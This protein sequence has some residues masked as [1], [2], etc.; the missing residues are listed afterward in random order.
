[1]LSNQTAC[2]QGN[3][4]VSILDHQNQFWLTA[5][6]VG[7]CLGYG[8][9]NERKGVV[10]LFNRH[11]DEFL[12]EDTCVVNLTTQGQAREFRVFSKTGCIKL[13]FFAATPK[14]KDFR[15]WAAC[16]LAGG[17]DERWQL[18]QLRI[19]YLAEN[20]EAVRLLRYADME[21]NHEEIGRLMGISSTTV[22]DR[23][24]KLAAL[25]FSDYRPQEKYVRAGRLGMAAMRRKLA[26]E[27]AQQPLALE[28]VQ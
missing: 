4:V 15:T 8:Q 11:A 17:S 2:F 26:F 6:D 12:P 10:T 19:A 21:L 28:V 23:L 20:P 22:R 7:R 13:G 1:M 18:S 25:G 24:K 3:T 9:G 14:A 27:A 16:T 5:E